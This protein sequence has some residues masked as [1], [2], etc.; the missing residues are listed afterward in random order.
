MERL[1]HRR[2][3]DR[4]SVV[5]GLLT[6]LV[7]N[8]ALVGGIWL[9]HRRSATRPLRDT[10]TFVDARL[11]RFGKPRDLSFL[12][13]V[14]ATPRPI[15]QKTTLKLA[16]DP[17]QPPTKLPRTDEPDE[18]PDRPLPRLPEVLPNLREEPDDRATQEAAGDSSGVRGGTATEAM[19]DPYIRQIMAAITERWSV[20]TMLS[21]SELA[22]LQAVACLKIDEDGR[23]VEFHIV[24]RSG[25]SLFD[26]SLVSTLGAIREL[27]RPYGPFAGAARRGKL[28]PVFTKQ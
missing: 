19:G 26:G 17:D 18:A 16:R 24:E 23:L 1:W 28:C 21:P 6:V 25:N 3:V 27:P 8:G 2:P 9:S 20:P 14:Q 22:K 11:V 5:V 10:A 15:K 4:A 12:P 13:H 7:V